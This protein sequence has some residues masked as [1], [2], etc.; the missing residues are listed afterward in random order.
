MSL[1]PTLSLYRAAAR[2]AAPFAGLYLRAR[3]SRGKEDPARLSERFGVSDQ[4]RPSGKLIWL[5]GAS[6]GE[7][8]VLTLLRAELAKRDPALDFLFTTGTRTSADLFA[9]NAPPKS[10]HVYAPLDT[11][12]AVAR[13]FDHWRPDAGVL[14]ESELWPNLLLDAAAR[15]IPMALVNATLSA[16]TR[17]AWRKRPEA[18]RAI[19]STFKVI[20]AA[21]APSASLLAALSGKPVEALANLKF[22]APALPCDAGALAALKAEIGARPLWLAASTHEGE[23]DILI[24]AHRDIR[25]ERP[26]ALLIIAPRHPDRG[27]R[28]AALAEDAPQRSK[29]EAIGA[30][31]IY[32]ADTLGEL[33]LFYAAA[34]VSFVGGSLLPSLEGHNPIEPAR[35]GSAILSGPHVTSFADAYDALSAEG[36]ARIVATAGE[37]AAMVS[38]L[39][40]DAA[41]RARLTEA[42]A[43]ATSRGADALTKTVD[44]LAALL[45]KTPAPVQHASA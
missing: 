38:H 22:A 31:P 6:V 2:A 12:G 33:G 44:A 5:H 35:L 17:E 15:A 41:E 40:G 7:M 30:A 19:L 29:G 10:R 18:A 11:P 28:I 14:V 16:D 26:D 42:A 20:A 13:F 9:R 43:R 27:A 45:P 36:G 23:E 8:G 32:V 4:P 1:P 37:I 25:R 34:P 24:A 3:A 39:L 21:E